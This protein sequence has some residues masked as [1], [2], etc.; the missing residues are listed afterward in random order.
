MC[1][2]AASL[3]TPKNK[4]I[5]DESEVEAAADHVGFPAGPAS[6]MPCCY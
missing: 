4:L 1:M 6:L 3:P 5:T 2:Q